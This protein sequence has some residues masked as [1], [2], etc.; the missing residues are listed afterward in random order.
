MINDFDY[1]LSTLQK[2]FL[3]YVRQNTLNDL[4]Q[5]QGMTPIAKIEIAIAIAIWEKIG[6]L[7]GDLLL[8]KI[9]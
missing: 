1:S 3:K 6:D 7:L 9:S 8:L 2:Y 4:T 5:I